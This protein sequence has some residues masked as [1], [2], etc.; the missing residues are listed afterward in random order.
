[1]GHAMA[2]KPAKADLANRL[3]EASRYRQSGNLK[4]AKAVYSDIL[5]KDADNAEVLH[6]LGC[7]SEEMGSADQAIKL[8]LK[9]VKADP[10]VPAYC[11]NLGN[12]FLRQGHRVEAIRYYREAIR[13]KPDYAIA[14]NNLGRALSQAGDREGAKA[15]FQA[16]IDHAPRFADPFN[17]LGLERKA[18]GDLAIRGHWVV[19]SYFRQDKGSALT[20]GW[21]RGP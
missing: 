8:V 11:Y 10:K 21:E 4:A 20:D 16:A 6:L 1:M 13:L 19:D 12:M 9:A 5:R 15:C 2:V 17:S 3:A 18:Q 14:H 7:L